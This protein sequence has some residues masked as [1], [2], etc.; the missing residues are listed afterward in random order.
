MKRIISFLMAVILLCMLM[1]M[2]IAETDYSFLDN[3]TMDELNA[4]NAEVEKR[5]S[6]SKDSTEVEGKYA[7]DGEETILI[8]R[9]DF[10][11]YLTGT[12]EAYD[13]CNGISGNFM[14]NLNCVIENKGD[15]AIG[16]L[17]Y[18]G[19]INGWSL[20]SDYTMMNTND[21]QPGSKAKSYIW[22]TTEGTEVSSFEALE[23]MNLTIKAKDADYKD[24]FEVT[25]GNVYFHASVEDVQQENVEAPVEAAEIP[26]ESEAEVEA[27]EISTESETPIETA[28][29]EYE[30]LEVGSRGDAVVALQKHLIALGYLTGSADGI[31]GNG[32]AGGVSK[33][34]KA[35]GLTETGIADAETQKLLVELGAEAVSL[36]E[37][38][39][40]FENLKSTYDKVQKTTWYEHKNVP[41]YTDICCYIYPYIG[42]QDNGNAWL[43]VLLNYTDAK[44]DNGWIF[45]NKVTFC[46]DG[47]NTVKYFGR[48]DIV[49]DNDT[50]V[51]E[52]AD[53]APSAKEIELLREISASS[54]TIIRFEGDEYYYDHIV[55]A[56]EKTAIIDVLN[57]YDY[58]LR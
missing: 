3:M 48:S 47:E 39:S 25:T 34:Q 38:K 31:Y 2:G 17:T 28:T 16:G 35:E 29:V 27:A 20:G 42:R 40:A 50:E 26:D 24:M 55:T 45:F 21:I 8:D 44:T 52:T 12:H 14:F 43:R 10:V 53:F 6:Q 33:F 46:I 7:V 36:A 11:L 18:N 37:G 57:A 15:K 58:I 1:P 51:W 5:I 13:N 32:T 41:K 54:E 56:K 19:L 23:S 49:R 30:K 4:L 9:P 22:F